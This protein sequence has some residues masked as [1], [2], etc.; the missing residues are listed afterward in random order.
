MMTIPKQIRGDDFNVTKYILKCKTNEELEN[1]VLNFIPSQMLSDYSHQKR[2]INAT[3]SSIR[4]EV[5][6]FLKSKKYQLNIM[7]TLS[8]ISKY[9]KISEEIIEKSLSMLIDS[10][11]VDEYFYEEFENKTIF[12]YDII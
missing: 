6:D 1:V 5:Y 11:Y 9:L 8:E 2:I 10:G 4:F 7:R 12:F 3:P